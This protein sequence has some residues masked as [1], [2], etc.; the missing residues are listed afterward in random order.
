MD[1]A[2]IEA[3]LREGGH[4]T[5]PIRSI[6]YPPPRG[7]SGRVIGVKDATHGGVKV[8]GTLD[9]ARLS[10]SAFRS[11]LDLKSTLIGYNIAGAIRDRYDALRCKPRTPTRNEY[12]WTAAN[13]TVRGRAQ[14]FTEGRLI[15]DKATTSVFYVQKAFLAT[16]DR[17]RADGLALDMPTADGRSITGGKL[18][19][20][21]NG[22][23]YVSPKYGGHAVYGAILKKYV[24]TGGPKKWGFPTT[25][26]L[27][28]PGGGRSHRF[29]RA[30]IYWSPK[31]DART[32]FG[33]ILRRY[34]EL[35]GASGKLG[36][37]K[38]D[39][40]DVTSGRR[41]DFQGGYITWDSVTGESTHTLT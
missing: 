3:R 21:E 30:R 4:N 9:D 11:L 32:V 41:Q 35:G 28:A 36:L 33:A 14:D 5:G 40:Y 7:V 6:S 13:G 24:A 26:Q 25:G 31:Y 37:P 38:S 1:D 23:I 34:L 15:F 29:E 2:A 20:F 10:G 18:A 16:L 22:N 12:S 19:T 39:E 8:D 17:A 27:S